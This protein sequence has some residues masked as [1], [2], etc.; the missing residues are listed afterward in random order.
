M[1]ATIMGE[2]F[3]SPSWH[4]A[5]SDFVVQQKGSCMAVAGPRV[6]ELSTGEK[7]DLEELGGW[8]LHAEVTG[9]ADRAAES[10][11]ECFQLVRDFLS[12]LPSN[13]E[14]L[15]PMGKPDIRAE[16]RQSRLLDL[17]PEEP[18]RTY[19]MTKIIRTFVDPQNPTRVALMMDVPDMDALA[20]AM[21]SKQ[22]ADAMAYDGVAPESL[23]IL[24]E[25]KK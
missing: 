6:L 17:L 8:Q 22:A 19:D 20:A 1:V 16:E 13:A 25:S 7:V 24:V 15:P 10:E 18:S 2:C 3:G 21:T 23:V 9:Q 11:E 5:L 12:F 4:A 14:E